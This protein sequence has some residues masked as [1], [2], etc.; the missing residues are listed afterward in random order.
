MIESGMAK[1]VLDIFRD[2]CT[3]MCESRA[4]LT[5]ED[6]VMVVVAQALIDILKSKVGSTDALLRLYATRALAVVL[7]ANPTFR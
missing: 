5:N 7:R 6:Q 1:A 3:Q 2:Y 4:V